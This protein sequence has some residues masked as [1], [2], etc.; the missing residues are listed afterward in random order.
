[1]GGPR[2]KTRS[3]NT[4]TVYS[5]EYIKQLKKQAKRGNKTARSWLN[6]NKMSAG[7]VTANVAQACRKV[8]GMRSHKGGE[9]VICGGL[10]NHINSEGE[11]IHKDPRQC[12]K[13]NK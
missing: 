4:K 9:C 13:R 2:S 1:M 7:E 8:F 11:Y 3:Y 6:R 12:I 10:T 5:K